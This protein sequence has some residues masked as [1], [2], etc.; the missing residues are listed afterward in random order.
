MR[1][2]L[3]SARLEGRAVGGTSANAAAW[4]R[5]KDA[6]YENTSRA[7]VVNAPSNSGQP[8]GWRAAGKH[9]SKGT[10]RQRVL[11]S[12]LGRKNTSR[13]GTPFKAMHAVSCRL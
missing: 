9:G 2:I 13:P 1:C 8:P 12:P 3:P 11:L 5:A 7:P 4:L 10:A 6:L